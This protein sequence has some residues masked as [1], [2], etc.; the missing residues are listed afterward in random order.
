MTVHP[1]KMTMQGVIAMALLVTTAI[2]FVIM[3]F[4][5]AEMPVLERLVGWLFLVLITPVG[6]I[7][8]PGAMRCS[9]GGLDPFG[10]GFAGLTFAVNSYLWAWAIV[11]I[12]KRLKRKTEPNDAPAATDG[13]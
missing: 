11:R 1:Y 13:L 5:K 10:C 4:A 3:Q 6:W 2:L 12:R 8:L 7:G 9:C